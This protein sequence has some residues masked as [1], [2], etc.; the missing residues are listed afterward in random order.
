MGLGIKALSRT[1]IYR[2]IGMCGCVIVNWY[3]TILMI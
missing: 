1:S 2:I 3:G